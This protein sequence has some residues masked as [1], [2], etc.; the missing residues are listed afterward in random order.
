M[1]SGTPLAVILL[2]V[3]LI[4]YFI[5]FYFMFHY[6]HDRQEKGKGWSWDYTLFTLAMGAFVVLQPIFL[7]FLSWHINSFIGLGIQIIGMVFT[8]LSFGLHIWARF[9]LRHFYVERVEVQKGH[10]LIDTGPY[11]LV[12]HPVITS[13]FLLAWGIFFINPSVPT[14][15]ALVYTLWDFTHSAKQEE[16]LLSA[17]VPGYA[18]YMERTPRFSPRLWR[19]R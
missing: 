1:I 8:V 5:D 18:S 7:P 16:N 12:R 2:I 11:A 19:S 4:F 10:K 6:D 14:A 13:F 3:T 15:I 17:T 9:H